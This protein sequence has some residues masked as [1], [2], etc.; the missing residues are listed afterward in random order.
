MQSLCGGQ[1]ERMCRVCGECSGA[2]QGQ[3]D[4]HTAHDIADLQRTGMQ[5]R[6]FLD[7]VQSQPVLL[8]PLAGR[9]KE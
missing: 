6:H 8:R 9:G 7:E 4:L 1:M 5:C 2:R 3:A